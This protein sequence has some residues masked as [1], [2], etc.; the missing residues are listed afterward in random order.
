MGLLSSLSET[1]R[2]HVVERFDQGLGTKPKALAK[3]DKLR[4]ESERLRAENANLKITDEGFQY[5]HSTW[6]TLIHDNGGIQSTPR[7]A[8][9]YDNAV[10]EN[11]FGHLRTEMYHGENFNTVEELI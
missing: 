10:I 9:C 5:Q 4:Y 6:R 11:F 2:V 8:N 3:E 1:Q 7:K